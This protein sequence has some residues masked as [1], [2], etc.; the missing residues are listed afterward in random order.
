MGDGVKYYPSLTDAEEP[1]SASDQDVRY[2]L[3]TGSSGALPPRTSL[4]AR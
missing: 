1:S 2:K 4:E 3:I